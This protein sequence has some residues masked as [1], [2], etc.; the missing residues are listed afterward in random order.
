MGH[1]KVV[2]IGN[3]ERIVIRVDFNASFQFDLDFNAGR[4]DFGEKWR[5]TEVMRI[6]EGVNER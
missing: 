3:K 2:A 6:E 4:R 1:G 5:K